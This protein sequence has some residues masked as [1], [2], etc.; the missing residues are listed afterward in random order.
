MHTSAEDEQ[1]R[2]KS[3][4]WDHAVGQDCLYA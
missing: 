4:V 1:Q 3:Q 2:F